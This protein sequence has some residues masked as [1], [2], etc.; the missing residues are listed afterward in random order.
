MTNGYNTNRPEGILS[1]T[2]PLPCQL[3]CCPVP[4]QGIPIHVIY[5]EKSITSLTN[6]N[7]GTYFDKQ[8]D[9]AN[10]LKSMANYQI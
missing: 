8:T 3:L 1:Q 10:R 5:K 7:C 4:F 2:H 9:I 6:T